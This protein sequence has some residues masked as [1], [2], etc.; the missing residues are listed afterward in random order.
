MWRLWN[1]IV[2]SIHGNTIIKFTGTRFYGLQ[3]PTPP[4]PPPPPTHTHTHTHTHTQTKWLERF[5]KIIGKPI[6]QSHGDVIKSKC[7]PCYWAFV[8]EFTG[9]RLSKQWWGWWF[10]TPSHP[11]WCHC[12][13]WAL[14][15]NF[16]KTEDTLASEMAYTVFNENTI[17]NR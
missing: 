2:G 5:A 10:V 11:L 12:N 8:W 4:P 6:R 3:W 17:Q 7:F 14:G 9:Y 1:R 13:D 16:L 15:C